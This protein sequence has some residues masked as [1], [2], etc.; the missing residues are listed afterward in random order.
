VVERPV[1]AHAIYEGHDVDRLTIVVGG[2]HRPEDE[3]VLLEIE[4]IAPQRFGH[5]V[6][7]LVVQEYRAEDGHFR[8]DA[9]RRNNFARWSV[10]DRNLMH[11][12]VQFASA[13][14]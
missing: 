3:L 2:G 5:A 4:L 11:G 10:R 13:P 14:S 8:L 7:N 1:G 9:V 6:E 12:L